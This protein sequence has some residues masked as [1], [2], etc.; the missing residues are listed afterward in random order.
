MRDVKCATSLIMNIFCCSATE[1]SGEISMVVRFDAMQ[2]EFSISWD[3]VF[4]FTVAFPSFLG[5]NERKWG[6]GTGCDLQ[7]SLY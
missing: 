1:L 5:H 2:R 7:F 3:H 4:Q 6:R